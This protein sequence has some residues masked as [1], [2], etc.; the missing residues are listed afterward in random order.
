MA[1]IHNQA[2]INR[3]KAEI[4][5]LQNDLTN[6]R[7][8]ITKCND[9]KQKHSEFNEKLQCVMNNLSGNYVEAGK[10]YDGGMML[11]C[12]AN[13]LSTIKDCES[14]IL[15]SN[16]QITTIENTIRSLESQMANLNG[17]CEECAKAALAAS[18]S[19]SGN[20]AS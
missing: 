7:S 2:K 13:A 11:N 9:I 5:R 10:T 17:D 15:E 8:N 16:R 18:K 14:I 12:S 3:I 4:Q 20:S 1:C 19:S 6:L